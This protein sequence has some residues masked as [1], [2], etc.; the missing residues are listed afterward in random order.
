MVCPHQH[1]KARN[2]FR[3]CSATVSTRI[4]AL[5]LQPHLRSLRE[6]LIWWTMW[7]KTLLTWKNSIW[8]VS[9]R[10]RSRHTIPWRSLVRGLRMPSPRRECVRSCTVLLVS[11]QNV[12][13]ALIILL[14]F[15]LS[16]YYPAYS[17]RII[18]SQTSHP[19][20]SPTSLPRS[21]HLT[22]QEVRTQAI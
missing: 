9:L 1:Q 17:H 19:L 3:H 15:P 12:M 13:R 2:L 6:R 11:L 4:R 7:R 5:S 21:I 16:R 22:I 18:Y 8:R 14:I 20:H 10:K